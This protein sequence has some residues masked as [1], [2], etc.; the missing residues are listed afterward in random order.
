[1]QLIA[2]T[3][4]ATAV[5]ET[6]TTLID[7]T[8]IE[9]L[10]DFTLIVSNA[11]GGSG[12]DITDIRIDT[13][14]DAGVT[15]NADQHDGVPAVPVAGGKASQGTFTET[16]A[17]VRVRAICAAGED[18]TAEAMLLAG[19]TAARICTLA[20][21]KDR[22]AETDT[23]NDTTLLN[24][25]RGMEGT[26]DNYCG[27]TLIINSAD[28]TEYFTGLGSQLLVNRYPVASITSIKVSPDYDFDSADALVV[29]QNYRLLNSGKNG[30]LFRMYGS[31]YSIPD[32]TQIVYR[33]GYCPAGST[34]GSGETALPDDLREAAILQACFI[35]SRKDDM[36][37]AA[38]SFDGGSMKKFAPVKLLPQV[39]AILKKYKRPSI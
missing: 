28:V 8:S 1:M 25:I 14:A 7:W 13:S 30:I 19:S 26:F 29:N 18:T 39:E 32:S 3:T 34:P 33:G 6:L 16:A 9:A 11:G 27:R 2:N 31:W 12:N 21:V 38:T 23:E 20:D 36:G 5:G 35:F 37:V 4:S 22:L 17:F 15:V 10:A 24:I